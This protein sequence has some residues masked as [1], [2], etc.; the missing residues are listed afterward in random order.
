M[1]KTEKI[2][3]IEKKQENIKKPDILPKKSSKKGLSLLFFK[4]REFYDYFFFLKPTAIDGSETE[5]RAELLMN[6]FTFDI[7]ANGLLI[8]G[9]ALAFFPILEFHYIILLGLIRFVLLDVVH[10]LFLAINCRWK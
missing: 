7:F 6:W 2:Q 9:C 5:S 1:K 8:Y 10:D 4:I 3:K